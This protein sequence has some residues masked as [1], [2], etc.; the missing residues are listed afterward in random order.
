MNTDT[1]G[2]KNLVKDLVERLAGAASCTRQQTLGVVGPA[3]RQQQPPEHCR[4]ACLENDPQAVAA[5]GCAWL[6]GAQAGAPNEADLDGGRC[7]RGYRAAAQAVRVNDGAAYLLTL[8]A[9][10][11]GGAT[12]SEA[13]GALARL[14]D[15]SQSL[16]K[17]G[18]L[19]AEN[20]GLADEVL[21]S[22]EQLNLIFDFTQ[23]IASLTDADEIIQALLSRLGES[24]STTTMMVVDAGG[25]YRGYD[26]PNKRW[27]SE[28]DA[29]VFSDALGKEIQNVQKSRIVSVVSTPTANI[30]LG[31]LTRLDNRTDVVLAMRLPGGGEFKSGDMLMIESILSFGGQIIANTEIQERLRRMSF[32]ATRALVAAIDKKDHYTSGHSERVGYLARLV[33][34]RLGV[35]PNELQILEMSGLLHDVGKIGIPEGILCKP[36]KLTPEEYDV[37]KNHPRMGY[38][39][40]KPIASFGE[41][42]DGVLYHHEN[43]DGSGYPES[44]SNQKIPLFA[45]IIHVVDVF[46]ALTTTRS[47]RLAFSIEQ[48]CDILRKEAGNKLDPEVVTIFLDLLPAL[49]ETHPEAFVPVFRR[50]R[51]VTHVGA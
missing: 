42:L 17:V 39:I 32:E 2:N 22:Y 40:L 7:P 34:H 23:Q 46:D 24:L 47:Y 33:G 20:D 29:S 31:P 11:D 48:A 25:R 3:L 8:G 5:R 44:L 15:L 26:V 49:R 10:G 12:E 21:R 14:E 27:I 38:E 13:R 6:R 36:G 4:A 18:Q 41:V 16:E 9:D 51:E 28:G 19:I 35:P 50:E 30:A 37:I 1:N 45:R 43:P